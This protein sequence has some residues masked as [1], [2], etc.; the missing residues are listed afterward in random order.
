[1]KNNWCLLSLSLHETPVWVAIVWAALLV[2]VRGTD[3]AESPQGGQVQ[4]GLGWEGPLVSGESTPI[5]FWQLIGH[6][7]EQL[8]SL[9]R[10]FLILQCAGWACTPSN[11]R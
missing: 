1:M 4:G 7:L 2:L 5:R 8:Q 6:W 9:D 3:V 11:P 10:V